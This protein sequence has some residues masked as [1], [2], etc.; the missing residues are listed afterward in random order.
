MTPKRHTTIKLSPH[1]LAAADTFQLLQ[2]LRCELNA[3]FQRLSVP[4]SVLSVVNDG[5][6]YSIQLEAEDLDA[7]RSRLEA[8]PHQ[9]VDEPTKGDQE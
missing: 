9:D 7:L 6:G 1:L 3:A 2:S 5:G 8:P 4:V